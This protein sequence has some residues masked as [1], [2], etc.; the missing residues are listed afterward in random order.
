M[1]VKNNLKLIFSYLK[2]NLKKEAIQNF[3]Y[4]KNCDDGVK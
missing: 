2:L 1:A 4:L 3:L